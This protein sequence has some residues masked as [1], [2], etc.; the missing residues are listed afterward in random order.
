MTLPATLAVY[1]TVQFHPSSPVSATT[2]APGAGK[3]GRQRGEDAQQGI[4]GRVHRLRPPI[5]GCF[6]LPYLHCGLMVIVGRGRAEIER[7]AIPCIVERCQ[8]PAA[9]AKSEY[10]AADFRLDSLLAPS[11]LASGFHGIS[12]Q[13]SECSPTRPSR[14]R[15]V[16]PRSKPW[17]RLRRG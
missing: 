12:G 2:R 8:F 9:S 10:S 11:A 1:F 14:C 7:L 13:S 6:V 15:R 16:L 17:G 4:A 5:S 3:Q